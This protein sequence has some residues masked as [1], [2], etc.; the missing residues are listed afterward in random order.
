MIILR[1]SIIVYLF[2]IPL[3]LNKHKCSLLYK[4]GFFKLIP[5]VLVV[6]SLLLLVVS[7][8]SFVFLY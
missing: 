1:L 8:F 4:I 3:I 6:S 5:S 2:I 7:F